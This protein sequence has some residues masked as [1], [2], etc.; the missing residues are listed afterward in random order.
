MANLAMWCIPGS[1]TVGNPKEVGSN[2]ILAITEKEVELWN[3]LIIRHI[4][5]QKVAKSAS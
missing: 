5:V 3:T 4:T 1:T 2:P